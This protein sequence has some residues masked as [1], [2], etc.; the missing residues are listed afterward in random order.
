[1]YRASRKISQ[2]T[3]EEAFRHTGICPLNPDIFVDRFSSQGPLLTKAREKG[4][5]DEHFLINGKCMDCVHRATNHGK[6]SEQIVDASVEGAVAQQKIMIKQKNFQQAMFYSPEKIREN[7]QAEIAKRLAKEKEE[8][9]KIT[10]KASREA[11]ALK[12]KVHLDSI[13]SSLDQK[14]SA[15]QGANLLQ[16]IEEELEVE[17]KPIRKHCERP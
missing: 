15:Q 11:K 14:R 8:A 13:N 7:E 6:E 3:I 17:S 9:E 4:V 5:I 12:K 2:D 16:S 10:R 1:M